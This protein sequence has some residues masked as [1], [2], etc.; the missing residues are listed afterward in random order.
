MPAYNDNP[1]LVGD[2]VT[3]TADDSSGRRSRAAQISAE[4]RRYTREHNGITLTLISKSYDE[5]YG[6]L[7]RS[8]FRY[9]ITRMPIKTESAQED[10]QS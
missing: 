8:A 10:T 1:H 2:Y 3:I 9:R 6:F 7:S 4:K 5:M